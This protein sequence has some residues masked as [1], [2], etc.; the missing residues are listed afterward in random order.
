M[1]EGDQSAPMRVQLILCRPIE[2]DIDT[3]ARRV[4]R[5]R[6]TCHNQA[7]GGRD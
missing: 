1:R 7:E 5:L 6:N 2:R 3:V 4:L